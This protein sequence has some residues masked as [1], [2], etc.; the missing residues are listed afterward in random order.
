MILFL[1]DARFKLKATGLVLLA[2]MIAALPG[3]RAYYILGS[4]LIVTQRLLDEIYS[5]NAYVP[6]QWNFS[7]GLLMEDPWFGWLM[8]YCLWIAIGRHWL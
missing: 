5:S 6:R 8:L 3:N 7:F 4:L 1:Q 2:A